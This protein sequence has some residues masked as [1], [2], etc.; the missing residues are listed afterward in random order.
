MPRSRSHIISRDPFRS[1]RHAALALIATACLLPGSLRAAPPGTVPYGA[2]DP[3]GFYS[4]NSAPVIEHIFL[5]WQDVF[6]PSL[7]DADAY[8]LARNRALLVTIEPWT[9]TRDSRNTPEALQQGIADGTYDVNMAAI[10]GQ[11][12]AL[13]SPVTVRWGQ[14]MEVTDGQ[15]IW[16]NWQ[17][18]TFIAAFRRMTTICREAAPSVNI[19]WSP[20]G[21][22][23][24][25]AY[26]PG[27]AYVDLVGLSVFGLQAFDQLNFGRD[28][29]YREILEPRYNR[30]AAF[31]KPVVVAELGYSGSAPYVEAWEN[32]VRRE[33]PGYPSL[34]GVVYFNQI[35]VYPWPNDLGLPDWRV[36]RRVTP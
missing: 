17:P 27:D 6:L 3:E 35:E 7:N 28:R 8:A 13:Q 5:P 21:E 11:I 14:E 34:V 32:E 29:S 20:L 36:T 18:T 24:M 10:C 12:N 26:Y 1:A 15:F 2:Y 23:G 22:E 33:R 9:W 31:G 4:D 19:M 30:A 16:S 25:E